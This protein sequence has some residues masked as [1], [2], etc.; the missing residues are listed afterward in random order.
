MASELQ[1]FMKK[2]AKM[3]KNDYSIEILPTKEKSEYSAQF[4][5]VFV[6]YDKESKVYRDYK[7]R[8]R[9]DELKEWLKEKC[10]YYE[11]VG[12]INTNYIFYFD[13]DKFVVSFEYMSYWYE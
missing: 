12:Y 13:A 3:D 5:I 9:V 2:I 7:N 8:D 1:K 6:D 10:D 11:P 4:H